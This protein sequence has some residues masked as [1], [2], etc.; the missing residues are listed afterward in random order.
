[1]MQKAIRVGGSRASVAMF[2]FQLLLAVSAAR[3]AEHE[4]PSDEAEE[5]GAI[6]DT[7][8]EIAWLTNSQRYNRMLYIVFHGNEPASYEFRRFATVAGADAR[9]RLP[10]KALSDRRKGVNVVLADRCWR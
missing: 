9:I 2:G 1:M 5:A 3:P 7:N 4:P 8:G 6:T 10:L